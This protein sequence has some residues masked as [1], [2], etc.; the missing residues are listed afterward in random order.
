M[1]LQAYNKRAA[2]RSAE[3]FIGKIENT[4]GGGQFSTY[5]YKAVKYSWQNFR[6]SKVVKCPNKKSTTRPYA[7]PRAHSHSPLRAIPCWIGMLPGGL[8]FEF[9]QQMNCSGG[10]TDRYRSVGRYRSRYALLA[11][12]V[13]RPKRCYT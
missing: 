3:S 5:N 6:W 8:S 13:P 2:A 11:H 4:R 7:S 1:T 9:A 10:I 12:W